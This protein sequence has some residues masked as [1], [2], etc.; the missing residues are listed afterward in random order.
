[1]TDDQKDLQEVLFPAGPPLNSDPAVQSLLDQ[2]RLMV[3]SSER[4]VARRQTANTFFLSI[5]SALLVATGILLSEGDVLSFAG[6]SLG[7]GISVTGLSICFVW[8]RMITSFQQLNVAK[9]K[10]IHLL[11]QQLPA[12]LFKAEWVALGEG[13]DPSLYRPFTQLEKQ[14]PVGLMYVYGLAAAAGVIVATLS[15]VR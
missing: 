7:V 13:E 11:E 4:V 10:I 6:G 8:W 1:M 5:N 12:A 14:I 2:Y 9:F 3:E 15:G